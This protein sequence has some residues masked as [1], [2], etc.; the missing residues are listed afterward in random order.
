MQ[1]SGSWLESTGYNY[2]LSYAE[3]SIVFQE[4]DG[5]L[6]GT[7]S[8]GSEDSGE[9]ILPGSVTFPC[10]LEIPEDI[11]LVI[12]SGITLIVP[13]DYELT[14]SG[15]IDNHGIIDVRGRLQDPD[16]KI[17]N[18]DDGE[19]GKGQVLGVEVAE[20]LLDPDTDE[21]ILGVGESK[22]L[23]AQIVPYYAENQS[24]IWSSSNSSIVTV[25][26]GTVKGLRAGKAVVTAKTANG[27]TAECEI[28]VTE[29]AVTGVSLDHITA[30]LPVNDTLQLIE[31][32]TPESAVNKNV[33]WTSE[34]EDIASVD[35]NGLVTAKSAGMTT[36]TV[37]TEDGGKTAKCDIT[38]KT[39]P[40]EGITL[41]YTE[42]NLLVG[43]SLKLN[44][45]FPVIR[46]SLR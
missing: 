4:Q 20:I 31:T 19:E 26:A 40:V 25:E 27:K 33:T 38:V 22:V 34:N 15:E 9:V 1:V 35:E 39:V 13:K 24:V 43:K 29:T 17:N 18:N 7:V 10:N 32:I 21:E 42:E 45:V 16:E 46:R 8:E 30:E 28:T 3:G 44:E 14:V 37:T 12:P 2:E 5:V 41:D 23:K 6:G 11:V 36:I